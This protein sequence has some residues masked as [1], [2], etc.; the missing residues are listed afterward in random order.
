MQ[1]AHTE[2]CRK[3]LPWDGDSVIQF[4]L[5]THPSFPYRD[6]FVQLFLEAY[7]A[8]LAG[9]PRASIIVG[10]E[11]LLRAI[12]DRIVQHVQKTG[13]SLTVPRGRRPLSQSADNATEVLFA[14]T[15]ELSFCQAVEVLK[16][17]NDYSSDVISLMLVIKDLRNKAVHGDLPILHEWDP[18]DPRPNEQMQEILFKQDFEFPEGYRFI[19][20]KQRPEWF[21]F[22]LR[23][24]KCGSLKQLSTEDRFAAIQY[25][26]VVQALASMRADPTAAA[27]E[28]N[29]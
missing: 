25:L 11:A 9:C 13:N 15:D 7:H 14:L 26:L 29:E 8:F 3:A 27:V 1:E 5:E 16:K 18:D 17:T 24:Y 6:Q 23:K 21:T 19:P 28:P 2:I 4:F 22:D 20:S 10:G 12:Y